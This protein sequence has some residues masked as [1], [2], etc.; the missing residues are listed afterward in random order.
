MQEESLIKFHS[1]ARMDSTDVMT[2]RHV[3]A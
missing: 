1:L 3:I 2:D